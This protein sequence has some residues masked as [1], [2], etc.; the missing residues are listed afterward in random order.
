M[1]KEVIPFLGPFD[2]GAQFDFSQSLQDGL[3]LR[4]QADVALTSVF[5]RYGTLSAGISRT[6]TTTTDLGVES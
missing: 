2:S 6:A 3:F 5:S 4:R 1:F